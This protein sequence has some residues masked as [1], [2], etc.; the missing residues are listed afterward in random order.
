MD[1]KT[2]VILLAL[3]NF[4]A[5]LLLAAYLKKNAE[6]AIRFHIIAQFHFALTSVLIIWGAL[7]PALI[8]SMLSSATMIIGTLME[9]LALASLAEVL[10]PRIRKGLVLFTIAG[11]A[12]YVAQ[13]LMADLLHVRIII[14]SLVTLLVVA[15]PAI[16]VLRSKGGSKLRDLL[17]TMYLVLV[18]FSIVR[19]VDAIRL[20][21]RIV[22]FGPSLG[23]TLTLLS[24]FV[25]LILGSVG[26]LLLSKEKTDF[27]LLRLAH[28][29]G[30]TGT[31]NRDGFIDTLIKAI[32]E[33]TYRNEPF[34]VLLLDIDGLN[35]INEVQGYEA[36]DRVIAH[37]ANR[38][39][40]DSRPSDFVGRLSGDEFMFFLRGVDRQNLEGHRE[41]PGG[42]RPRPSRGQGV[43]CHHRRRWFRL[44]RGQGY[45]LPPRPRRLHR[46]G[47]S[48][49]EKG[50]WQSIRGAD[51]KRGMGPHDA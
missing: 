6:P 24:L 8:L 31:L 39:I 5:L 21:P 26:I 40:S 20:G 30:F 33:C 47:D 10:T 42:C 3:G 15:Y 4:L 48:R 45:Q 18:A 17:G 13:A 25:Y 27:R 41:N 9:A 1:I 36:G 49:Q 38:L 46:C 12:V 37:L 29:D 44:S 14:L 51:L 2:V 50:I 11:I 22:L 19:I 16:L 23:E 34:S 32:G 35:E 28:Y 43:Q 7:R